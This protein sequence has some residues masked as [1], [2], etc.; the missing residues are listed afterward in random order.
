MAVPR[1]S[2]RTWPEVADAASGSKDARYGVPGRR[3]RDSGTRVTG[4]TGRGER[5][6]PAEP[7]GWSGGGVQGI[8]HPFSSPAW[9]RSPWPRWSGRV[10]AVGTP[11]AGAVRARRHPAAGFNQR[12]IPP[13]IPPAPSRRC[14]ARTSR[15]CRRR[16][17]PPFRRTDL[18][19]PAASNGIEHPD[20]TDPVPAGA[21]T[22]SIGT[23]PGRG[24]PVPQIADQT[25][26]WPRSSWPRWR[27]HV[28]AVGTPPAG[29]DRAR[30]H[31]AS[32]I[33]G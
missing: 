32:W 12:V 3:L 18:A 2:A 4:D 29:A 20:G 7:S 28:R 22:F 16:L 10:R 33:N 24:R 15:R 19:G 13:V 9:P 14:S 23:L 5:T 6:K 31:S 17:Q 8:N 25:P 11:P 30:R 21:A 27:G 26:A 1:D